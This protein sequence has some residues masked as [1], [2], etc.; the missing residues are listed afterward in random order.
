M[1]FRVLRLLSFLAVASCLAV[2]VPS[3]ADANE[4]RVVS[5]EHTGNAM[6]PQWSPDGQKIAYEVANSQDKF[7][8]LYV[9]TMGAGEERIRPSAGASGLSGRFV[10]QKQ[11]N[12][13]FA[14]SPSNQLYAFASSGSN[15]DFDLYLRGVTVPIGTPQKEGGAAFSSD[16]RK[17]AYCSAVS[18]EGDLYLLDIYA[19]EKEPKRLTFAEGLDFYATWSPSSQQLAYAAMSEDGA[20]IHVIDDVANPRSSDRALTS[21]KSNQIKPAWSPDGNWIAFFSNHGQQDHTQF[22]AYVVPS[23]G[24]QPFR[25]ATN[26]VP[27][28]RR[29]P[30]WTPDSKSIVLV[31]NDPNL[32][33][34][35]IRID[36]TTGSEEILP[37]GTVNNAEPNLFDN[38][39]AGTWKVSFVSQGKR[40]SKA[41]KWRRIWV[42]EMKAAS[43]P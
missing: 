33:D 26:V 36:M 11:V 15:N 37:T 34:P 23:V 40:G 32:G 12:H 31:R 22:D 19:L 1:P 29:G 7:T 17:I 28:E 39:A 16:G 20:N 38:K 9:L 42:Y 25:V 35:L 43:R 18:G 30:T 5:P 10:Q 2:A 41:Q 13:E 4:A 3:R 27:P 8:D 14:W 21:W 24:G 6:D